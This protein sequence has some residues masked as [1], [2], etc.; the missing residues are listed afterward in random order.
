[1]ALA[2]GAFETVDGCS[3]NGGCCNAPAHVAGLMV[4]AGIGFTLN[5]AFEG[6]LGAR[7]Q[8]RGFSSCS[9]FH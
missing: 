6:D 4:A 7:W 2:I 9:A 5:S 1:M 8:L 3:V